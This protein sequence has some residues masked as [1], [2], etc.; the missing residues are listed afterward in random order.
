[1]TDFEESTLIIFS[2]HNDAISRNSLHMLTQKHV[3][4]KLEAV[5]Y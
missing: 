1:M 2:N 3:I 4:K 5:R